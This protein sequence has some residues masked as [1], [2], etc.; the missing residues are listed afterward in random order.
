MAGQSPL[1]YVDSD[2]FLGW[3]KNEPDKVDEC[4]TVIKGAEAGNV[5]LV[6][7]SITLTEVIKLEKG[8]EIPADD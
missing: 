5:K 7:S 8:R 6:T 4:R 3:L 1:R 2:V